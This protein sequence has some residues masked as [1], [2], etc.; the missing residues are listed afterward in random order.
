MSIDI[1][2]LA[3]TMACAGSV[4]LIRECHLP[5]TNRTAADEGDQAHALA[6]G[7]LRDGVFDIEPG[8]EE[9]EEAV[10]MYVEDVRAVEKM[11]GCKAIVEGQVVGTLAHKELRG[12]PD[13]YLFDRVNN[14]LYEWE[15]KY[16]HG[17]VE[18]VENWQLIGGAAGALS[19]TNSTPETNVVMRIVQPRCF[20]AAGP[21]REWVR[22]H[23][24]LVF[25]FDA[26]RFRID[27]IINKGLVHDCK[28][29]PE[30]YY[31]PA[32]HACTTLHVASTHAADKVYDN[33]PDV[34]SSDDLGRTLR[35]LQTAIKTIESRIVGL[36]AD[37]TC[38]LEAG[39]RVLGYHLEGGMSRAHWLFEN[40]TVVN[41]GLLM[42][43]DLAKPGVVTPAQAKTKAMAAGIDPANVDK[44]STRSSTTPTLKPDNTVKIMGVFKQ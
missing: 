23:N 30:C 7:W 25:Y 42:G 20:H 31:C 6:R 11:T 5:A 9:M 27:Q 33:V 22:T 1:H 15:F 13:A 8:N 21:I 24:Q 19:M 14:T 3:R 38:R 12:K 39:E 37:A 17:Y 32:A 29:S 34:L 18:C 41:M 43:L 4:D 40:E 10:R 16:G 36:Q 35:I 26:I 44:W 2:D 28:V